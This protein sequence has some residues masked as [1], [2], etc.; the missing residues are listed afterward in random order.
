MRHRLAKLPIAP[1]IYLGLVVTIETASRAV[2]QSIA[3]FL[4]ALLL[5]VL[6][7][8]AGMT[9]S[10]APRELLLSLT[11][12][13]TVRLVALSLPSGEV[14]AFGW[15]A[16]IGFATAIA[17]GLVARSAGY[18]WADIGLT[19]NGGALLIAALVT[20][21]GFALGLYLF[22]LIR[23]V[24]IVTSLDP[25]QAWL[26]VLMLVV[27]TGFVEELLFRGLL[28]RAA[29]GS[30]GTALGV[31]YAATLWAVVASGWSPSI[32][33]IGVVLG[34]VFGL[35]TRLSGSIAPAAV[36]HASINVALFVV[37]P[38]LIDARA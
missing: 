6:L 26:P 27:S 37:A 8:H 28:Q 32:L 21:L 19:I 13:S 25:S 14:D 9:R 22:D 20:P 7:N 4:Y 16:L 11:V 1:I 24:P 34:L 18:A 15:Y 38:F 23:P 36:A 31:A 30:F 35:I 29:V 2:G 17:V 5:I 33:L 12:A 10:S 3:V